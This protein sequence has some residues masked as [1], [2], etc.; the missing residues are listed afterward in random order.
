M[1]VKYLRLESCVHTLTLPIQSPLLPGSGWDGFFMAVTAGWFSRHGISSPQPVWPFP[2]QNKWAISLLTKRS[3]PL[4]IA[5][6]FM[7]TKLD[8][9]V[10]FWEHVFSFD[11]RCNSLLCTWS[12]CWWTSSHTLLT[13]LFPIFLTLFC[14]TLFNHGTPMVIVTLLCSAGVFVRTP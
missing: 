10:Q 3:A 14:L 13:D 4:L 5:V 8:D 11:L 2:S 9:A 6:V 7:V 12:P 1:N